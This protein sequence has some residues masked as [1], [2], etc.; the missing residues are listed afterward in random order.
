MFEI[1]RVYCFKI[2]AIFMC[3]RDEDSDNGS[4]SNSDNEES[5]DKKVFHL[6]M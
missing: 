2:L 5:K 6:I 3:C 1:S 4:K